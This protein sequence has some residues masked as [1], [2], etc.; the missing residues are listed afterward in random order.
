MN[1]MG[2]L[3]C[4]YIIWSVEYSGLYKYLVQDLYG[5]VQ[6]GRGFTPSH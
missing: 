6:V 5:L 1:N 4:V 3:E 2:T